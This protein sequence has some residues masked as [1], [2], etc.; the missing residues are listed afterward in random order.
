MLT[1]SISAVNVSGFMGIWTITQ[2]KHVLWPDESVFQ[3]SFKINGRHVLL[4]KD[5]KEHPELLSTINLKA[6]ACIYIGCVS[7]LDI[8]NLHFCV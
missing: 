7:T 4:T 2:W 6:R 5:E 8:G 1:V 3:V